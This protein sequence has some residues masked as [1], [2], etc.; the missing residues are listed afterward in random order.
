MASGLTPPTEGGESA[1]LSGGGGGMSTATAAAPPPPGGAPDPA[2]TARLSG[3]IARATVGEG[4]SPE[5][6]QEIL[7]ALNAATVQPSGAVPVHVG[8]MTY[9]LSEADHLVM[10]EDARSA[11]VT[12]QQQASPA[13][14][15]GRAAAGAAHELGQQRSVGGFSTAAGALVDAVCSDDDS[16]A[17]MRIVANF[18]INPTVSVGFDFQISAERENNHTKIRV[19]VGGAVTGRVDAWIVEAWARA[20]VHGYVEAQGNNGT[21]AI[22]LLMY[23]I[24]DRIAA[25]S[26][27]LANRMFGGG[28]ARE[29]EQEMGEEDYVETGMGA[30]L[31][32]GVGAGGHEGP[33]ASASVGGETGTRISGG[34]EGEAP[35]RE[36]ARSVRLTASFSGGESFP[37]VGAKIDLAWADGHLKEVAFE[38][39]AEQDLDFEH[40]EHLIGPQFLGEWAGS[41]QNAIGTHS[42]LV[43]HSGDDAARQFGSMAGMTTRLSGATIGGAAALHHALEEHGHGVGLE[44][45]YGVKT[46]ISWEHGKGMKLALVLFRKSEFSFGHD[47]RSP[48][49]VQLTASSRILSLHL[50][51]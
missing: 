42:T 5:R 21:E 36:D 3:A 4:A 49:F 50:G 1:L 15:E 34:R 6:I 26:P 35:H 19:Q 11:L 39:E 40:F 30:S 7:A 32:G 37:A 27:D 14:R 10:I 48:L 47:E 38:A 9:N 33:R 46:K 41:L 29:T 44:V 31:S 18:P 16:G 23:G 43:A 13:A 12:A 22:R 24:R 45:K 28:F 8:S 51:E 25:R 20:E 17:D 2:A